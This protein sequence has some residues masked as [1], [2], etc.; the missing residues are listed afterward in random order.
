MREQLSE[1]LLARLGAESFVALVEAFGGTRLY[2]PHT[3]ADDH[4]IARAIG[5]AAALRLAQR[6]A[7]D[8]LRIPLA[9]E[10]RA[11]HYRA[12]GLSNAQIAR[13]IGLGETAVNKIF[14]RMDRVPVKGSAQL[15][16]D[17]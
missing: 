10:F 17:I 13:K 16:L 15:S 11:R 6:Y 12:H 5:T 3:I 7:P 2:V 14:A 1:A 9:R 4:E 8:T